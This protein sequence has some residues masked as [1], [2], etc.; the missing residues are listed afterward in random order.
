MCAGYYDY[1]SGYTPELPG[2]DKFEGVVVHPQGWP[3]DLDYSG[4]RVVVIGSGATAVTLQR[5]PTYVVSLPERDP[6]AD[7][8]RGKVPTHVAY[9]VTRWKNILF[10]MAFYNYCRKFPDHAKRFIL[11]GV[12]RQSRGKI[13][14]EAHFTPTYKPWDQRL[15]LVPDGDLFKSIRDGRASVVTD[16][17]ETFTAKGIKLKSGAEIEA[18]IIVTATG[19]KLKAIGGMTLEVDG[20]SLEASKTMMYKGMMCSDVPNMAVAIGY[21][22]ASWTLKC[23]L[24]SEYVCR[25]LN[26]MDAN[27]YRQCVPRRDPSMPELPLIDF[28]SGYVQRSIGNFP[29]QGAA[30]PWRLYQNYALDRALFRHGRINDPAMEFAR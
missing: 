8:M 3:E 9:A 12:R 21:T 24:S 5:S 7:K 11:A 13:D 15:C 10:S 18:D 26:Y 20:K 6:I 2:R 16:H 17:I 19:L 22:N 14:V 1:D 29:R 27:G 28:S 30:A 23:D 25:L 4:K